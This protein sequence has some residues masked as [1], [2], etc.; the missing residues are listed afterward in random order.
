MGKKPGDKKRKGRR[1]RGTGSIFFSDA[2]QVWI[3]RKVV[4]KNA[5]GKPIRVEVWGATQGEV[6]K[7]LAAA[8]PPGPDTTVQDWSARWLAGL[9]VRN[10]TQASYENQL[11]HILK[12]IGGTKAKDVT[13]SRVAAL[14]V[15]LG[16]SGSLSPGMVRNIRAVGRGMFEAARRDGLIDVNPFSLTRRPKGGQKEIFPFTPDELRQ[17]IVTGQ[18]TGAGKL[19]ALLAAVGCR[20]GEATGLDVTDWDRAAGTIS[21]TKTY[22]RAFGTGPPKSKNSRRTITVPEIARP[23]LNAAAGNRTS[24]PL[25]LSHANSRYAKTSIHKAFERLLRKLKLKNRNV[26]QL[27]HSIATAL[28]GAGTPLGDVAKFLGDSVTTIVSTYLH[29][30]GTDPARDLDKLFKL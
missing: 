6:V 26:H 29:P 1:A 14:L 15:T 22:S 18:A 11:S 17:I 20:L 30:S 13:P 8:S 4:G 16:K 21:I 12:A 7:K 5:K 27:R 3:G 10:S 9:T 2:R 19:I 23:I 28:I 25:L 24:G